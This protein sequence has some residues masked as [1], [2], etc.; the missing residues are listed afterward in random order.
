MIQA[1]QVSHTYAPGGP[2]ALE[3]IDLTIGAGEA[4]ALMGATGAGKST[5]AQIL[6]GLLRPSGGQVLWEGRPA[7]E[8]LP[9]RAGDR[10]RVA[11]LFQHPEHQLFEPT[12]WDDVAFGPRRLGLAPAAVKSRVREALTLVGLDPEAMTRRSPFS[13]SGGEQRRAALAGLLAINPR[14]LILDE[15]AAGLDP[16]GVEGLTRLLGRLHR[17]GMGL[18]VITHSLEEVASWAQRLLVLHQGRLVLD[19]PLPQALQEPE[20]LARLGLEPPVTLRLASRLR[21]RGLPLPSELSD[22]QALA[23]SIARLLQRSAP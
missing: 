6:A 10:P 7:L 8:G 14:L 15:P 21:A 1:R 22:P 13:L 2:P 18:L 5:L 9:R 3:G 17:A 12:V 11:Y 20:Q 4:V 16:A 19:Q 23:S